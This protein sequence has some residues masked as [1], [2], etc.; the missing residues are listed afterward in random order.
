MGIAL[1]RRSDLRGKLDAFNRGADDYIGIPFVPDD[2]IARARAVIRRVHGTAGELRRRA[3]D[4][5]T[6][7]KSARG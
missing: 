5:P 1:T 4:R 7:P 3:R 6:E 2:L